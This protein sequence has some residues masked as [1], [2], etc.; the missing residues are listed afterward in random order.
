[1]FTYIE[2]SVPIIDINTRMNQISA[3]LKSVESSN[4]S[5]V[6][7]VNSMQKQVGD[8]QATIN[9]MY[10]TLKDLVQFI[11]SNPTIPSAIDTTVDHPGRKRSRQLNITDFTTNNNSNSNSNPDSAT[12]LTVNPITDMA[13]IYKLWFEQ[14][15]SAKTIENVVLSWYTIGIHSC[16]TETNS[17]ARRRMHDFAVLVYYTKCFMPNGTV[18]NPRPSHLDAGAYQSWYNNIRDLCNN[19]LNKLVEFLISKTHKMN[20]CQT[21]YSISK[22]LTKDIIK[23]QDVPRLQVI[24]NAT[25]ALFNFNCDYMVQR[26]KD[27]DSKRNKNKNKNSATN[28]V[29]NNTIAELFTNITIDSTD[30]QENNNPEL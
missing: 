8:M 21:F 23:L 17:P 24:D 2:N 15:L 26:E 3:A 27:R 1:M 4:Y 12:T 18:I 28:P 10:D 13:T 16:P 19:A 9:L 6:N 29:I 25:Y 14:P 20:L 30:E 11:A 7:K 5:V 22:M